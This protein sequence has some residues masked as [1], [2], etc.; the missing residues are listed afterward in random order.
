MN[1][2]ITVTLTFF[3]ALLCGAAAQPAH[4]Q[5]PGSSFLQRLTVTSTGRVDMRVDD[6]GEIESVKLQ[7]YRDGDG[8]TALWADLSSIPNARHE[9]VIFSLNAFPS[10]DL[11]PEDDAITLTMRLPSLDLQCPCEPADAAMRLYS[12]GTM[13]SSLYQASSPNVVVEKIERQRQDRVRVVGRFDAELAFYP[14]LDGPPDQADR[15][16]VEGSF[17]VVSDPR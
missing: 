14:E 17:D 7:T 15:I 10:R 2:N 9:G 6:D 5:V 11:I 13:E 16:R 12:H 1:L 8:N 3:A 4:A